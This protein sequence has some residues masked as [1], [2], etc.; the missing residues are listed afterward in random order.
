MWLLEKAVKSLNCRRMH[1]LIAE[2]RFTQNLWLELELDELLHAFALQQH[3]WSLLVHRHAQFIF[4]RE[5]NRVRLR[6][7]LK[8]EIIE[9]GSQLG[10]LFLI[11]WRG[12]RVHVLHY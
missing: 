5:E 11:E 9:Q 7:K 3:L 6:R 10:H 4:L 2:L 12:E 1:F 8:A